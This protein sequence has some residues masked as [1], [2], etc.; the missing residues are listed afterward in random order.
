MK[1]ARRKMGKRIFSGLLVL[2]MVMT[3]A[4]ALFCEQALAAE[5]GLVASKEV[6]SNDFSSASALDDFAVSVSSAQAVTPSWKVG[7][8]DGDTDTSASYLYCLDNYPTDWGIW[9]GN[10][11]TTKKA[12]QDFVFEIKYQPEWGEVY[13][14]F[15]KS[16][17][18]NSVIHVNQGS[19]INLMIDA[20]SKSIWLADNGAVI[21]NKDGLDGK[22]A[23]ALAKKG[24]NP[25][26]VMHD[27]KVTLV[28]TKMTIEINGDL[29]YE[30]TTTTTAAGYIGLQGWKGNNQKFDDMKITPIIPEVASVKP[31]VSREV[32]FGTAVT[33]LALPAKVEVLDV[34]NNTY[35]L[36]VV[37]DTTGYDANTA[38]TY[39]IPGILTIADD[40]YLKQ[41]ASEVKA[42]VDVIVNEPDVQVR[43]IVSVEEVDNVA[44]DFGTEKAAVT[45]PSKLNATDSN[46]QTVEVEVVWNSSDYDAKKAGTYTFEGTL[47]MPGNM[48][49]NS[50]NIKATA[51][52]TV[53]ADYDQ[54]TTVKY[55]FDD[56]TE[57]SDFAT[58][59]LDDATQKQG[60]TQ[61]FADLWEI[62]D[63]KLVRKA[64]TS[65]NEGGT[66]KLAMLTY[67]EKLYKNFELSVKIKM[68]SDS[69]W[70][71]VVAFRQTTPG[72]YF[73]D[74]GVGAFIQEGGQPTFWGI[75][76]GPVE[77][78]KIA[79]FNRNAEYTM[80]LRVVEDKAEL[81][82]NGVKVNEITI[83][84]ESAAAGYIS[85]VSVN[86][87]C[88]FDDL[89]ITELDANGNP[90]AD[91][92]IPNKGDNSLTML[93]VLVDM[94][95][96][97]GIAVCLKKKGEIRR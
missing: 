32:G 14:Q 73:L 97:V 85:L 1:E 59:W 18:D 46:N 89:M 42:G 86:N 52:V 35:T 44:V 94:V 51:E 43:E 39:T 90:V 83:P 87:Q 4:S 15:R 40:V 36:P 88:S 95:A 60:V 79:G 28:G 64:P 37:W 21:V 11:I 50:S 13:F 3:S 67:N 48:Y 56:E 80:K 72:Y 8:V 63:G 71:P 82:Y 20:D 6:Y 76:V 38:G 93:W 9:D 7:R 96:L 75:K 34:N 30:Y 2:S 33:E 24:D 66:N 41:P 29:V 12:Y 92:S 91:A 23:A 31:V 84:E 74:N 25:K 57:L 16:T 22:V 26:A 78:T 65:G 55:Y 47:V 81:Y 19:G 70:W 61:S 27:I 53:K 10:Y 68:G 45:L 69:Y 49:Q 5:E 58:Y 17:N 62:K 77:G 54:R